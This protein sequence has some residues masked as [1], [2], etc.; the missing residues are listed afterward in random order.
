[1]FY[2]LANVK[3][4][5]FLEITPLLLPKEEL[6]LS[7]DSGKPTI[8]TEKSESKKVEVACEP[9]KRKDA[10]PEPKLLEPLPRYSVLTFI[11]GENYEQVHEIQNMQAGVEYVLV[12][13]NKNLKSNTW[14]VVYDEKLLKFKTPFERCFRVRYNA[15]DYI[16]TDICITVDGSME[17]KGS[18][19]PLVREF[20]QGNYDV[21]LMPHPFRYDFT[22]EYKAWVKQ[23]HYP[24]ERLV[25]F[26][27]LLDA[28]GYDQSFKGL[29]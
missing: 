7:N 3:R 15:F 20:I 4:R 28:S 23:R 18:L 10:D 13:D 9:E 11:M 8:E 26:F 5:K 14:K 17:V 25:K 2:L 22:S 27:D 16:S 24:V 19:D 12:T 29:I 21:C 6:A 1:M